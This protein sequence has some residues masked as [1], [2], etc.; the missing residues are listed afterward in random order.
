MM[1]A[2]TVGLAVFMIIAVMLSGVLG[3]VIGRLI[4]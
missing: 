1:K 4:G 3:Y 2:Y